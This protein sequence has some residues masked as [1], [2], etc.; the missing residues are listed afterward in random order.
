MVWMKSSAQTLTQLRTVGATTELFT[1]LT[2]KIKSMETIAGKAFQSKPDNI[3]H[4]Y[5]NKT[6]RQSSSYGLDEKLCTDTDSASYSWGHNWT[7]H[8]PRTQNPVRGRPL[9]AK[10]SNPDHIT[11]FIIITMR[12]WGS[13][14]AM[15]WMK[16]S[17]QTMTWPSYSWGHNWTFHPLRTQNLVHGDDCWQSI[18][19]QTT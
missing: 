10:H 19:I 18:P 12:H 14:A 16:S 13:S 15:V 8:P 5:N 9:L 3:I 17:A 1:L 4:Y 7:F 11:S 2:L 6:L